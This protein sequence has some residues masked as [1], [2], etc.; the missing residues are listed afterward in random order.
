MIKPRT[1]AILDSIIRE[2]TLDLFSGYGI[3]LFAITS[4]PAAHEHTFATS[5]GFTNPILPGILAIT[6]D[7]DLLAQSR[8]AE[9]RGKVPSEKSLDDWAGEL[10]NQLLGRIKNQLVDHGIVLKASI[11]STM[12]GQFLRRAL[13]G[14]SISRK[15]CFVKGTSSL[16]VYF[17]AKTPKSLDLKHTAGDSETF[18]EGHITL[19]DES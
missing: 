6:M 11:P 10:C 2:S 18:P 12:R 3:E 9:L 1:L 16:C 17:D 7:G 14:A 4:I 15:M 5:I 19:F 13:M 8:P